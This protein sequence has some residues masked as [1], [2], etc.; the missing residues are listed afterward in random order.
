LESPEVRSLSSVET[1]PLLTFKG[2]GTGVLLT[3][4]FQ[5]PKTEG[6]RTLEAEIKDLFALLSWDESKQPNINLFPQWTAGLPQEFHSFIF[7]VICHLLVYEVVYFKKPAIMHLLSQIPL[8][9]YRVRYQLR[10]DM[11]NSAI[12]HD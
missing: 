3:S 5:I 12:K 4:L 1:Y 9:Y 2:T 8:E 7:H 11:D 6:R 10:S